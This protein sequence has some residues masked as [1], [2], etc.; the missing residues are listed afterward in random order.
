MNSH[1]MGWFWMNWWDFWSRAWDPWDHPGHPGHPKR[2]GAMHAVAWR[3][4]RQVKVVKSN[5]FRTLIHKERPGHSGLSG[6]SVAM[7]H[8]DDLGMVMA[9]GDQ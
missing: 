3:G 7:A 8:G 1:M 2:R 6:L 9:L 5:A 4:Q